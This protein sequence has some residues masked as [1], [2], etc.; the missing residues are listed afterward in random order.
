MN[1]TEAKRI[2]QALKSVS[3]KHKDDKVYTFDTN[4][5]EMSLDAAKTIDYLLDVVEQ[6]ESSLS[7]VGEVA[8]ESMSQYG[9]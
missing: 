7:D 2:S 1:I 9:R 6:L 4:I 5:S 8:I 3:K